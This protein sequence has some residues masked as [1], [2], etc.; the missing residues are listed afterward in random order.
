MRDAPIKLPDNRKVRSLDE[1]EEYKYLCILQAYQIKQK[2][3]KERVGEEYERR[4]RELL[5]TKLN[6]Q[7]VINAINT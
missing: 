1:K 5:E 7:N 4:V 3:M 6:G 2:E